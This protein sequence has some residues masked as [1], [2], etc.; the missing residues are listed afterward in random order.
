MMRANRT[1][2]GVFLEWLLTRCNG[3]VL[4]VIEISK[5][6]GRVAKTNN[7]ILGSEN[8]EEKWREIDQ[9]VSL[10]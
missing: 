7:M 8:T 9:Q 10:G 2:Q 4:V 6:E 1:V 3:C 5:R